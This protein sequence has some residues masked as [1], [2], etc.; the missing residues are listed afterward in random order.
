VDWIRLTRCFRVCEPSPSVQLR[1]TQVTDSTLA[2]LAKLPDLRTL[3]LSGSAEITDKG[4]C[5][6]KDM[7]LEELRIDGYPEIPGIIDQSAETLGS[8]S[9]LKELWIYGTHVGRSTIQQIARNRKLKCI[10][11]NSDQFHLDDVLPLA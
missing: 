3:I 5:H 10:I 7:L 8:F 11:L 6:L 2:Q 9:H 4:I 1:H